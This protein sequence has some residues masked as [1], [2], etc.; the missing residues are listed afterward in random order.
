MSQRGEDSLTTTDRIMQQIIKR[1][2]SSDLELR[3][4][5]IPHIDKLVANGTME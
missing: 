5:A 4:A 1:G 3:F 2:H